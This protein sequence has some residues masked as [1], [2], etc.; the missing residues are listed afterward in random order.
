[1]PIDWE[2][3]QRCYGSLAVVPYLSLLISKSDLA[4]SNRTGD[5][6]SRDQILAAQ[7]ENRRELVGAYL[8]KQTGDLARH[9][10]DG[11]LECLGRIDNQV[12]IRGYRIELG[13]IEAVLA[14]HKEVRDCVVSARKDR[15]DD[16]RLAAYV[17]PNAGRPESRICGPTSGSSCP[18][19][20]FLRPSRFWTRFH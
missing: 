2:L 5:K 13:E 11:R 10:P 1:M 15:P 6:E 7:S 12:K 3:W 19:T 20:W 9:F 4:T 14:T 8:A 16:V 17:V 18:I